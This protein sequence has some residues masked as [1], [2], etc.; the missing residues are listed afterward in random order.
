VSVY[1]EAHPKTGKLRWRVDVTWEYPDGSEKRVRKVSP[2]NTKRGAEQYERDIRNALANGTYGKRDAEDCEMLASFAERY[3]RDHIGKLKP[4]TRS[5]QETIWRVSLLP[6][7]G[8][9]RLDRIDAAS[10]DTLMR[11][12]RERGLSAKTINNALSSLRTALTHAEEW[13]LI[14]AVPRVRWLKVPQQKFDFFTFEEAASLVERGG[15]PMAVVAL[16]TGMRIGELLALRWS[17]VSMERKSVTVARSVFWAKG[18]AHEGDTKTGK[19]RTLR[20]TGQVVAALEQLQPDPRKRTGYVFTDAAGKRLTRNGCRRPL[21]RAQDAAGLR[22]T[23]WHVCRHTF[24]S[25][26][27]MKGVPLATVQQLMGHTTI[28]MTM[29]YAHLA[30]DHLKSAMDLLEEPVAALSVPPPSAD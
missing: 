5:A 4:S 27:V 23:G 2:V 1:Q 15:L 10:I 7:L 11:V 6:V 12:L 30:P 22:R 9:T 20:L 28:A 29:K 21:W 14:S 17:D 24:A 13:K 16:K 3:F 18:T 26:L 19:V 8:D 25:H